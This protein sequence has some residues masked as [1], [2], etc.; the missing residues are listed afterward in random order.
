MKPQS[1][2]RT[3]S[4]A[5]PRAEAALRGRKLKDL[6]EEGFSLCSKLRANRI[7]VGAWPH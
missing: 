2:S 7:G 4:T 6:V 5:G 3:I 1:K